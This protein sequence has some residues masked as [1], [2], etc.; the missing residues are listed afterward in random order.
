MWGSRPRSRA[1][2]N[3][4]R[5]SVPAQ[6]PPPDVDQGGSR[7]PNRC[8]TSQSCHK[9]MTDRLRVDQPA[10]SS[11][12]GSRSAPI[13]VPD[14]AE[15]LDIDMDQLARTRSFVALR[16]LRADPSELAPSSGAL[17]GTDGPSTFSLQGAPDD[18]RHRRN[19]VIR[20]YTKGSACDQP[21]WHR[22]RGQR[23]T[24]RPALV[25]P[26]YAKEKRRPTGVK[27]RSH[28]QEIWQ[29]ARRDSN[30]RPSVP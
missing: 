16:G 17:G 3:R 6:Q 30:S 27:K 26:W 21:V 8:E 24:L 14:P 28:R 23:T 18:L 2:G 20:N 15:L 4:G 9:S 7:G 5:R 1:K 22:S 19:N 13:A 11:P 12:H 25:P 29:R 10:G